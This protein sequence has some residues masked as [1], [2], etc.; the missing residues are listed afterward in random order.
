[1]QRNLRVSG[2][3]LQAEIFLEKELLEDGKAFTKN[4]FNCLAHSLA[5]CILANSKRQINLSFN[6]NPN[7]QSI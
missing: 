3:F 6:I 5:A 1:M 2:D 7:L 4:L